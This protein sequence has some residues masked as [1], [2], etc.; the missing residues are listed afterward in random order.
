MPRRGAM[1]GTNGT[2]LIE[3]PGAD[4][5]LGVRE[6]RVS[7]MTDA[8]DAAVS[9]IGLTAIVLGSSQEADLVVGAPTVSARHVELRMVE[10]GCLVRDLGSRNG[11]FV[12]GML[13]TEC[14]LTKSTLLRLGD[15]VVSV[16]LGEGEDE[17]PLSRS[18]NFGELLGHGPAMRS[19]FAVLDRAARTDTTI[20]L[21]GESGTGKELA[22]RAIHARSP[23]AEGPLVVF[24]C[25]AVAPTLVE[26][27]LFGHAR[28]AFTGATEARPGVFEQASGGTLVLDEL[29]ELPLEL[30]PKLL[31]VLES[32]SVQRL[33][34][35]RTRE[36]SV[37]IVASTNRNLGEEVRAGRFREDL[38]FRLSVVSVHLPPLRERTEEIP[39]LVAHFRRRLGGDDAPEI[40]DELMRLLA[41]HDWPGN[42]RELRNVVE[43]FLALPGIDPAVVL[44]RGTTE[45]GSGPKVDPGRES[46]ETAWD[47]PFHDAKAR[48]TDRFERRYLERLLERHGGNISEAARIAGLSR[49]S[50]YRLMHKHGLRV[51]E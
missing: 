50:C 36:V 5:T 44:G 19:V 25:A 3:R 8:S 51:D 23:R 43:R 39:R 13:V 10:R 42:V 4:P 12:D 6:A 31:R 22:A 30:Q 9:R 14:T 29:G 21:L 24:D 47:L 46:E 7:W 34:E 16:T 20:L 41:R 2:R 48:L 17:V 38:F 32:R 40:P 11:T 37:R 18:T 26:S 33:G 49:Q 1:S 15:A 35:V 28:G 27:Q 45:P